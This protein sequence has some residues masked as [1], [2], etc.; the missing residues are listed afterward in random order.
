MLE[1]GPG[2]DDASAGESS[3][4]E[5]FE[6]DVFPQSCGHWA[7]QVMM[8]DFKF[9]VPGLTSS[10]NAQE[11]FGAS[12]CGDGLCE[13]LNAETTVSAWSFLET[14][15]ACCRGLSSYPGN[16]SNSLG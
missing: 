11:T 12:K 15:K 9:T 16:S 13:P 14:K 7:Q 6:V 2:V 4:S 10:P 5:V 8:L 1:D 3:I